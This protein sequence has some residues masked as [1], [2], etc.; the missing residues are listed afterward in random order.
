ME[1]K[2]FL[3][4]FGD[5]ADRRAKTGKTVRKSEFRG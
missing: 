4:D 1:V 5:L 2:R 3:Q